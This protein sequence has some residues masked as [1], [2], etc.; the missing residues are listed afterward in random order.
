MSRF[1]S[2]P[3]MKGAQS[4]KGAAGATK[5]QFVPKKDSKN[6][7]PMKKMVRKGLS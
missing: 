2:K 5:E 3:P 4:Q 6:D 7:S 1:M